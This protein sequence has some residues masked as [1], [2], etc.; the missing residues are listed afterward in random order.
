MSLNINQKTS[1]LF[2]R[3]K[4]EPVKI[5]KSGRNGN[6]H[7]N[8]DN[9]DKIASKI[10]TATDLLL[11]YIGNVIGCK[12]NKDNKSGITVYYIKG[13]YDAPIIQE[14]IYRFINFAS[15][16]QKCSLPE[17]TPTVNKQRLHMYCA[18]CGHSYELVGNN[19]VNDKLVDS[20]TKHFGKMNI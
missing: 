13:D 3:Y 6:I 19:K 20:M 9:L 10:N 7:T 16:C 12:S 15:I 5:T 4:M 17:L 2:Y 14:I 18:A 1:D 11:Q 8:L